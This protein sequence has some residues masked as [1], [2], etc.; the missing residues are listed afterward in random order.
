MNIKKSKRKEIGRIR[1]EEL[2]DEIPLKDKDAIDEIYSNY[3]EGG[4]IK[5]LPF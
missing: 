3:P 5:E 1:F 2:E 4:F